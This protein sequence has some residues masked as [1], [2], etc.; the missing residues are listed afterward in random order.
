MES[1]RVCSRCG[2]DRELPTKKTNNEACRGCRVKVEHV[3]RYTNGE[4]CLAWRG[5]FDRDDNPVHNGKIFMD[6]KRECG[7]RDCINPEHI[8]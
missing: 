5:D 8:N 1:K 4:T 3:I 7:H 6:G 2:I